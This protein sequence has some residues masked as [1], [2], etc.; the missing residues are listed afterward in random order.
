MTDH[1]GTVRDLVNNAGAIVNHI[2][3]SAFGTILAQTDTSMGDRIGFTGRE[4]DN[5]TQLYYYRARF[6]NSSMGRF[7]SMDPISFAGHQTNLYTYVANSPTITTDPTGLLTLKEF[8]TLAKTL[9]I[10]TFAYITNNPASFLVGCWAVLYYTL[11]FRF[12]VQRLDAFGGSGAVCTG[13]TVA[14]QGGFGRA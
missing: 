5:G 1:L 3:Y 13:L 12:N 10:D 11:V 4:I 7:I 6:Y 9:A 14:I 2:D 8:A